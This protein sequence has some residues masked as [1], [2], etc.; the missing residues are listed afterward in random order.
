VTHLGV[1]GVA[2]P[3]NPDFETVKQYVEQIKEAKNNW[4][5]LFGTLISAGG[6]VLAIVGRIKADTEIKLGGIKPTKPIE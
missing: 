3:E 2:L 6:F 1:E 4:A 5:T